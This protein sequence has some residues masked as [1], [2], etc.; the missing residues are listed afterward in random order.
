MRVANPELEQILTR[1][2]FPVGGEAGDAGQSVD[3]GDAGDAGPGR[4]EEVGR[5]VDL[6]LR[7][8]TTILCL[9]PVLERLEGLQGRDVIDVEGA[10]IVYEQLLAAVGSAEMADRML[11]SNIYS[12]C[13]TTCASPSLFA[14]AFALALTLTLL[15][16]L[17]CQRCRLHHTRRRSM[18]SRGRRGRTPESPLRLLR[19][20]RRLQRLRRTLTG[21]R[22]P[23]IWRRVTGRASRTCCP[24]GCSLWRRRIAA[25]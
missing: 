15:P 20:L 19:P 6:L 10:E 9:E 14:L 12:E 25:S 11:E 24:I 8:L 1:V 21:P 7:T 22:R 13:T 17:S 2:L 5:G 4:G 18:P 3:A 16:P 23:L